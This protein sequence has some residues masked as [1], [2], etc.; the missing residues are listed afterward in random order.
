MLD[1]KMIREHPEIVS[2]DLKKR[3]LTTELLDKVID[4]DKKWREY[5]KKRDELKHRKNV[6]TSEI[7]DMK[8]RGE[9]A[10]KEINEMKEINRKIEEID[11]KTKELLRERDTLLMR[12]PNILHDSVPIGRDDKDNVEIR[13]W[14]KPKQF[15][16]EVR[17]HGELAESLGVGDWEHAAKIAGAGF[18]YLK[19]ALALLDQ[20]LIQ[21]AIHELIKKHYT[22]VFPPFMM[23]RKPYEGVT[24]LEDFENVM[25]KIEDEDLYMIATSEH[26]LVAMFMNE[27]IAEESLP[28][29]MCGISANFRKEIGSH[30]VDTKGLFRMHQ[31]NKVEQII[32]SKPEESWEYH[33]ELIKNAEEIF[34]KLE[35]P[36]RV[37]NVCTGDI[38]TVAAKKYDLEVWSPRQNR[39]IE[40]VSCSNCTD[41][42]ARRLNIKYGKRGGET[43][44]VHTLN[45]TA[46]ATSRAMVA[47]L[48]NFQNEDGTVTIPKALRPYM[49]GIDVIK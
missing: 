39:Y 28:I 8:K 43:N 18:V 33:E 37:V 19:G 14:G 4:M 24:D 34:Q 26:P 40:A 31:F 35:L 45:S 41:Y 2:N 32:L 13:R 17:N 16:F 36:Y 48:E 49:H 15:T 10:T 38:G 20:A 29:K 5:V 1:I 30:G 25:Y 6:V 46:I 12:I 22:P 7:A 42:Q 9:D 23:R 47:I 44:L 11:K 21:F 3:G 27:V